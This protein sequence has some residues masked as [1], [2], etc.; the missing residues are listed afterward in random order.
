LNFKKPIDFV[1]IIC[2][3]YIVAYKK[4]SQEGKNMATNKAT[5]DKCNGT[6]KLN[7]FNHIMD[8]VCFRCNGTGK[9]D[10]S[11]KYTKYQLNNV[12]MNQEENWYH[13]EMGLLEETNKIYSVNNSLIVEGPSGGKLDFTKYFTPKLDENG[14]ITSWTMTKN[15]KLYTVYNY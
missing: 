10:R 11:K 12:W 3:I 8:G 9:I 1:I 2:Y 7:H 14:K 15:N 5:C 4:R 13:T 6:G